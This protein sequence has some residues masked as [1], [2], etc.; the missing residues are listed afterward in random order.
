MSCRICGRGNCT[1]SFHSLAQ[2]KEFEKYASM[3]E[4]EMVSQL[5]DLNGEVADLNK[6][7]GE[8]EDEQCGCCDH[9]NR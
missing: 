7:I 8:Y 2:Q 6:I 4:I 1:D 9:V 3:S 5:I